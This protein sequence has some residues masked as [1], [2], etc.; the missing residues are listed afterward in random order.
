MHEE[1]IDVL[2]KL[3]HLGTREQFLQDEIKRISGNCKN[4]PY[5]GD[6]VFVTWKQMEEL[7]EI[8]QE[9]A[10][11]LGEAARINAAKM[12]EQIEF[13]PGLFVSPSEYLTRLQEHHSRSVLLKKQRN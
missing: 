7:N 13:A 5:Q 3:Y 10:R 9:R 2:R 6:E 1:R 11:F 8:S 4:T 12:N